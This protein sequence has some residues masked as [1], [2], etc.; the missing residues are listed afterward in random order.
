MSK[1][2]IVL[3]DV[4]NHLHNGVTRKRSSRAYNA[5]LGSIEEKYGL[6]PSQVDK[7]FKHPELV[8]VRVKAKV[9]D[10]FEIIETTDE[11]LTF[12]ENVEELNT[13]DTNENLNDEFNELQSFTSPSEPVDLD[14]FI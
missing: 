2:K 7:L 10:M 11:D 3:S 4:I 1:V 9:E 14:V 5:E 6:P 13:S 12:E 8:G